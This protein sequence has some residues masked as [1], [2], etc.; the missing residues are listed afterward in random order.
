MSSKTPH[1]LIL[2]LLLVVVA[3]C[4][5]PPA[6]Q[7]VPT[8]AALPTATLTDTPTD[9]PV[10][11]ATDTPTSTLT[12]T[13]TA[14]FTPTFTDT[15]VPTFTPSLTFTASYTFTYTPTFTNTPTPTFTPS[16]TLTPTPTD[17]HTPTPTFTPTYTPTSTATRTYTP[18]PTLTPTVAGP[19]IA[20]FISSA[21]EAVVNSSVTL[22]W[23]ADADSVVLEQLSQQGAVVQSLRVTPSGQYTAVA[24]TTYG[25]TLLFRLTATRNGISTNRMLQISVMCQ[26]TWFFGNQYAPPNAG[27]PVAGLTSDG[28]YQVFERGLMIY[29][30]ANGLNRVYGLTYDGSRYLGYINGWDGATLDTSAPPSGRFMPQEMFNWVYYK[31]LAPVG[32][33]NSAIGWATSGIVNQQRTIQWETNIGGTNP[34]YIDAPDGAVYRFSGGDTGTWQRLR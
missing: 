27:C 11:T 18:S 31:S 14:T 9:T 17:T 22:A 25:R 8:L 3:A 1:I 13:D 24:T 34:F 12:P 23:L 33:W 2:V 5:R 7:V 26:Y 15:P 16:D 10:P 20:T 29:V 21:N 6:P 30:S 32:T 19:Q 28:R 4:T